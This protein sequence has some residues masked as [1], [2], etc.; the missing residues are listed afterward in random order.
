MKGLFL[1]LTTLDIQ[2]LI[3]TFPKANGKQKSENFLLNIGGPALNAAAT[4]VELGGQAKFFT[5]VGNHVFANYI[6]EECK[7][8]GIVCVDLNPTFQEFPI[9]ASVLSNSRNGDRSIIRNQGVTPKTKLSILEQELSEDYDII[10]VDGFHQEAAVRISK[11]GKQHNIPVVFDGGSWKEGSDELLNHADIAICSNDFTSPS[12]PVMRFLE[13]KGIQYR[14]ISHGEHPIRFE[15]GSHAGTLS[16]PKVKAIDS[17][18]AG[19]VFHGA[20]CYFKSSG[21][22]FQTSLQ[23]AS[24]IAAQST[25]RFGLRN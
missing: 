11:Y 22:D 15:E 8:L 17:L 13:N 25:T 24:K 4:F 12:L 10:L 18:G 21:D 6:L 16:V 14:A 19:D 20:F 3:N 9:I 5:V 2:Y 23:K 1:G 7:K